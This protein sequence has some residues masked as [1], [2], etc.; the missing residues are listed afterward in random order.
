MGAF[1]NLAH[2]QGVFRQLLSSAFLFSIRLYHAVAL[3]HLHKL[4][5]Y[6]HPNPGA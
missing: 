3:D 1:E 2:P 6:H 4:L 5:R